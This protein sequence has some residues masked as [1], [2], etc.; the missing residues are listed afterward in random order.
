MYVSSLSVYSPYLEINAG[1]DRYTA[2]LYNPG[3]A[4]TGVV[5]QGYIT[6]GLTSRAAGGTL[7]DCHAGLGVLPNGTC[8]IAFTIVAGNNDVGSGT[9]VPG[10]A[11]FDLEI[12]VGSQHF[13]QL[14]YV[15]LVPGILGAA[16]PSSLSLSGSPASVAV[17][18]QNTGSYDVTGVGYEV[19][20][21][22]P[23]ARHRWAQPLASCG[24]ISAIIPASSN[25]TQLL[26]VSSS[27]ESWVDGSPLVPGPA[28]LQLILELGTGNVASRTFPI[29]LTQ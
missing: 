20:I 5:A 28:T 13:S 6:Q 3:D 10:G 22:Q 21:M 2:T 26:T 16:A 27:N 18:V 17:T 25:C 8:Q 1:S 14:A 9:L 24:G 7:I 12:V 15:Q 11:N 4:L 29:T 23:G 19:W